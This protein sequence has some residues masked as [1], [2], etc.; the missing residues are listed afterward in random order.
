[1]LDDGNPPLNIKSGGDRAV[2]S[3]RK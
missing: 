3:A 1:L 2:D